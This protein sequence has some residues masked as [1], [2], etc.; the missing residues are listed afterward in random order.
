MEFTS[1]SEAIRFYSREDDVM[2]NISPYSSLAAE[3]KIVPQNTNY[4]NPP[5]P[6]VITYGKSV[7]GIGKVIGISEPQI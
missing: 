2:A 5:A 6:T 3:L 4:I 1:L 7:W